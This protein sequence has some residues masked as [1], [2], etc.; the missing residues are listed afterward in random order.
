MTGSREKAVIVAC[1]YDATLGCELYR[2]GQE[3]R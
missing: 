2:N 1:P 3:W